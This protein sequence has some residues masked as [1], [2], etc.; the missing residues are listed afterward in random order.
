[1]LWVDDQAAGVALGRPARLTL[2]GW[3]VQG[4]A[5]LGN[6]AGADLVLPENRIEAE[7]VFEAR[8]YFT[9]RVR[10]KRASASE[11]HPTEV[12]VGG[13]APSGDLDSLDGITLEVIRRDEE[14]EED[15]AVSLRLESDASL[16][17]PRARLL[18]ILDDEDMADALRVVG[19]PL[20]V[21]EAV[22]LQGIQATATFDGTTV[23]LADYLDS[24]RDGEDY[25]PFFVGLGDQRFRTAPED[26]EAIVLSAG[27]RLV[28]GAAVYRVD[29]LD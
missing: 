14:G 4:S 20:K 29:L 11:L 24:Y 15:F 5:T 28:V 17:D 21:G 27:D 3:S 9:L 2:V 16:P 22:Q 19:L 26:G 8:D 10:G 25:K 1:V 13:E 23:T 12:R 7:Q 6:H 18:R